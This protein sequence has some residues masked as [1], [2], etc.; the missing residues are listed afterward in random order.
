MTALSVPEN[1]D[2]V[3]NFI[4]AGGGLILMILAAVIM[5]TLVVEALRTF[6]TF[7]ALRQL[8]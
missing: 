6:R 7:R 3:G 4:G 5:S 8:S 2:A 1:L